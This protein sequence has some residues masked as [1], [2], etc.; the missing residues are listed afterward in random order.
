MGGAPLTM[1]KISFMP[2]S[3]TI[4]DASSIKAPIEVGMASFIPKDLYSIIIMTTKKG[5]T[6][7]RK[8]K[9]VIRFRRLLLLKSFFHIEEFIFFFFE[10]VKKSGRLFFHHFPF[11][12]FFPQCLILF[13][14]LLHERIV[15]AFKLFFYFFACHNGQPYFL[16]FFCH[17]FQGRWRT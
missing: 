17:D 10:A 5:T 13:L 4:P 8:S 3:S 2:E 7:K 12:P 11:H 6:I 15:L 16:F 9:T 1:W 14:S